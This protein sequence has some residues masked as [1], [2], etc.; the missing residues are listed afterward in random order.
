VHTSSSFFWIN[1]ARNHHGVESL[2]GLF[3]ER[4]LCHCR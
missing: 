2:I 4:L 1:L 3:V